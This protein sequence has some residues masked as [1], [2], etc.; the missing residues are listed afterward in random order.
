MGKPPLGFEGLGDHLSFPC[1]LS[2]KEPPKTPNRE[3][4][5]LQD[6]LR[7]L[8][9]PLSFRTLSAFQVPL[10]LQGPLSSRDHS[11]RVGPAD[12]RGREGGGR[13]RQTSL[14]R[15]P[16]DSRRRNCPV[17]SCP[18]GPEEPPE[19]PGQALHPLRPH[20]SPKPRP[21]HTR[22]FSFFSCLF[23]LLLFLCFLGRFCFVFSLF[24]SGVQFYLPGVVKCISL[25]FLLFL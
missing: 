11:A 17:F 21:S 24:S 13:K 15:L 18:L 2:P 16:S 20:L 5:I 7:P 1:P 12:V 19:A 22:I 8:G 6:P 14:G 4:S 25:F 9:P 23:L 3:P 10:V